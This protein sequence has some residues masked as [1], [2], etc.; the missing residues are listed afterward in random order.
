MLSVVPASAVAATLYVDQ[1]NPN[2]SNTG[3][4]GTQSIPY[5]TIG[6]AANVALAGQTVQVAAGNYTENVTPK[7]SGTESSPIVYQPAPGASVTISGLLHAFTVANKQWITIRG[8]NVTGT[9]QYGVYLKQSS[10]LTVTGLHVFACGQPIQGQTTEGIYLNATTESLIA[11]NTVDHNS[12]SGIY[13]AYASTGNEVR[14]NLSFANARKYTRGAV[15]ID[16]RSGGNLIDRNITYGNEDSG[17]QLYNGATGTVVVDNLSYGN[18]DHGVDVLNS[19]GVFI[20]GNTVNNSANSGI[21]I[22]GAKGTAASTGATVANNISVDN[23]LTGTGA[24]GNIRV[25]AQSTGGTTVDYDVVNLTSPGTMMVWGSKSY[26]SLAA[27][28][29]GSGQEL[30]GIQADPH[31]KSPSTGDFHLLAGS[32]AIDSASSAA[33][34]EQAT[35]IEDNPR[36]DDPATAN[37]G[38]GPRRYDDRGAFEY[39]FDLPPV[40]ALNVSPA[41]G[42]VPL[43]VTAD[44]SA[45]TDTD[46]TPIATY[47]FDFGDGTTVPAQADASATHIYQQPGSYTVTVTV[48]DTGGLSST[49]T[50]PVT[51]HPS[52]YPPTAALTVTPTAGS[53]PLDVT[54]DASGSTD[55]DDTPI[56]T[57]TFDFG[58]GTST[59]AQPAPT[60]AHTYQLAGAYTV[61]VTVKDTAGL[62]ST[63]TA[64]VTAGAA[65]VDELHY[66][67]LGPTS[68]ALDW[69]GGP[70]QIRYGPT[71]AY[72]QT[73]TASTPDPLPY[74][75]S[76]PFWE[77]VL[78]D[79][80]PGTTYHYSVGGAPDATFSTPPTGPVRF[81]VEADIGDSLTYPAV[82]TTQAQIAADNPAFVL[83]AGDLTYGE[84]HGLAAVDRHFNDVMAWS[85]SAA[86]MAAWGNHEYETAN[87]DLRNYKGRFDIPNQHASPGAPSLGCCGEDWGWF[88]AGGVRFISYPEPY[89]ATTWPEWYT[90]VDPL[91]A[92]A[93]ADPNIHF[94]VTFGHR[95]AY[96]TG[97]HA[98]ESTMATIQSALG[99][100]YTKY[101]LNLNG[102]SHDYERFRPI[103]GVINITAGG[104]GATLETP[105]QGTDPRTVYRA[106]HFEHLR[107]DV[108]DTSMTVDAICGP[109]SSKDDMTCDTG[110][111][112]DSVTIG[113]P[114]ATDSAPAAVLS[115]TP[116]S[117]NAPLTV[118]ADA[119]GSSDD[120][121]TPI[122]NYT[123]DFGDGTVIG[124]Q[125]GAT[126]SHTYTQAGSYTI[127][128]TVTDTAGRPST[129]TAAV[130]VAPPTDNPPSASLTVTPSSGQRPLP[131]TAD[132]SASTDTD[133]TPIA[134]YRFDFGDGTVV[135]PQA[136]ATADHTYT[137]AG[138]Y[139]V[140]VTVTDT[141]GLSSTATA[142]VDVSNSPPP[143]NPPNAALT[144]TPSS[145]NAPLPVTAD[146]SASTDTDATPIANY[147]FDFGDGTVVGPQA[148]ATAHHTYTQAGSYTVTVTVTDTGGLSST[149]TAS[150]D[151]S[152][153]PPPDNPPNASLT[154]TPSSGNAPLPV[155]ADASAS[156]DTDATP[157][158]NYRF[159]FGDGTVVG[160]QAGAT[161]QHTYT[162]AGSYTVTVT[163]TDT[164][165][166]FSSATSQVTVANPVGTNLVGNP[167]FETNT[168]GWAG[169]GS[170]VTLTRVSGGHSGSWAATLANTGSGNVEC[171]LNDS[172]NWI[173]TTTAGTYRG[174]IWV[175]APTAG[176]TVKIR[177][178]EYLN[179]TFVGQSVAQFTLTTAWQQI[180]VNYT[181]QSVG[182]NLDFNVYVSGA[183]PGNCFTADDASITQS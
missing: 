151:V 114:P 162:Q 174:S 21:N 130:T 55:P 49:A 181:V 38:V 123:F 85:T 99:D 143:D 50:A 5:C 37:I 26:T 119:S 43:Q 17:I 140:T 79:L 64:R 129:A 4:G 175:Q 117:G 48:V 97:N 56:A 141:G 6:A 150:V 160:P 30:H 19:T 70:S 159:D 134:N 115:A 156:T 135:G 112:I 90:K 29:T 176:T 92:A 14:N 81:D 71:A 168:T 152:N 103:H 28:T 110:S 133:A 116:A 154:V 101:V 128:V 155:T 54:A 147:R 9:T 75:S 67:Y 44:A 167:G 73:A 124:P 27:Y 139:T 47:A 137:Q 163:V 15:G 46:L 98:G 78:R 113:L 142:S 178:R 111:V 32:P 177:F 80:D 180:A 10:H 122:D 39:Q 40:A 121:A 57:Y 42:P 138:S 2:C 7:N 13:I 77:V 158:A 60:A 107:V 144:V 173:K 33:P 136:G 83:A 169:S 170:G 125:A 72:G 35:D 149:A 91:M 104:G 96:S 153:S 20:V 161:A 157:I 166:L 127:K 165:G 105:W 41:D 68:V 171:N 52:D 95:P 132:A 11:G 106:M 89:T 120:D 22:E 146:A 51:V 100:R 63:A 183:P 16:D 69:R 65:T 25:D 118:T 148:G 84:S 126:A 94:I 179:G 23:G 74:S 87:D 182:S 102:H 58:D 1:N 59:G 88:D 12:D 172:P 76:G 36:V 34:N 93:Q 53:V 86:Y 145:G 8:F 108:T 62:S 131:V 3:L 18:G 82:A 164:G 45:S 31:W 61:T 109:S 24:K 66:T